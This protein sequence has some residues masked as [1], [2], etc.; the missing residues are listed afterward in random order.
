MPSNLHWYRFFTANLEQAIPKL[1]SWRIVPTLG[2]LC[3]DH[4]KNCH[5]DRNSSVLPV[6]AWRP[7][8]QTVNFDFPAGSDL[9][10]GQS[11]GFNSDP[12]ASTC[13]RCRT[14]MVRAAISRLSPRLHH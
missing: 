8:Q 3:K 6:Y 1:W 7:G 13:V 2:L 12:M 11:C 10:A 5:G 4:A 9:L 14:K